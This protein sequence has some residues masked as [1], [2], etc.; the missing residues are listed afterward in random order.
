[1]SSGRIRIDCYPG[2]DTAATIRIER[3]VHTARVFTGMT[4]EEVLAATQR[5]FHVCGTAQAAAAHQ[6]AGS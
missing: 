3:P 6:R 2:R 1:M 5:L 4:P